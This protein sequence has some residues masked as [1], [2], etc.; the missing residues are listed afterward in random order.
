[1][2]VNHQSS[3]NVR[4]YPEQTVMRAD[5]AAEQQRPPSLAMGIRTQRAIAP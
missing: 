3:M 5:G 1:M 2:P 4:E